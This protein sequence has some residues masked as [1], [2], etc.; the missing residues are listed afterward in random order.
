MPLEP[1]N[2]DDRTF[3]DL[4]AEAIERIRRSCPQWTDL[5]ANDPGIVLLEVFAY[6]TDLMIYRLN[7]L[8]VKAYIEFLRLMGLRLYPPSAARVELR[9]TI[10]QP[11]PAAVE[12][13]EFTRVTV[14]RSGGTQPAPVFRTK[15]TTRIKPGATEAVVE[16]FNVEM[17]EAELAGVGTG[18]PRQTVKLKN[19]PVVAPIAAF[20]ELMVGVEALPSEIGQ[21]AN[22]RN[23]GGRTFRIWREVESFAEGGD[24]RYFYTIDR[25]SGV[26]AFAPALHAQL[27]DG[28]LAASAGAAAEYPASGREIRVWYCH[29]GGAEG[30]VAALALTVLKDPVAGVSVTNE[31]PATGGAAGESVE[32]ALLRGPQ[33]LHSLERAV[34]ARDFEMLAERNAA[35][36]RARAF[37]QRELWAHARPG[38]VEVLLV[39]AYLEP[40]ERGDGNV[41]AG[42]LNEQETPQ[43]LLQVQQKLDEVKPLGTQCKV[44]WVRYKTVRVKADIVVY[45]GESP[46]A[47]R[48]RVLKNLHEAINP[49][50][51]SPR[52][53]GWKFGEPLRV[54]RVYDIILSEPGVS[55]VDKVRLL[56]DDVPDKAVV[57]L[58]VDNFQ[59]RTWYS[60]AADAVYRSM[61]DGESW[62]RAW[63]FDG[64]KPTVIQVHP[65]KPGLVAVVTRANDQT[66]RIYVSA[67]CAESWRAQGELAFGVHDIAWMARND[68]AILLM[69]T[70]KGLY[71]MVV[72]EDETSPV[73]I[74]VDSASQDLGLYAVVAFRDVRGSVQVAVGAQSSKGVWLSTDAG[75]SGSFAAIGLANDDVRTLAV[76]VDGPRAFL[77]AGLAVPGNEPGQGCFR[78]EVTGS[79]ISPEGWRAYDKD[80]VGGSC[81]SLAFA[82]R[83]VLAATHHSG[84]VVLDS[85]KAE[86]RWFAPHLPSGLPARDERA[87]RGKDASTIF[88]PV[89]AAVVS[90][91]QLI[92]AGGPQGIFRSLDDGETY[93]R[94]SGTEFSERVA[95]PQTWLFCSGAHEIQVLKEEE[96]RGG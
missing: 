26:I 58:A 60:A 3:D 17:I 66:S 81:F 74:L 70:D 35:A 32:N 40:R 21:R 13:P 45:R 64:E 18:L 54:S 89:T 28:T 93:E 41:T 37:T 91:S 53:S 65:E 15:S 11:R 96:V 44:A 84:V 86:P 51:V 2:L 29:G 95:I 59:S 8:P 73:Q 27:A 85:G 16:A 61:N 4:M 6:L 87:E 25:V 72:G 49:L 67:D 76:Q 14:G 34:T 23:H 46:D 9:F 62:E 52:R 20:E 88:L 1:P 79:A 48:I 69:A 19:S 36:A 10:E 78:W 5:S 24:E 75:K 7:R 82:G 31:R 71:E 12:I 56:V 80:W 55:F 57:A 39:P 33:Q 94:V 63:T 47:V 22:A 38:T 50:P 30:N 68:E 83:R 42:R 92:L 77:W 43:A 90:P